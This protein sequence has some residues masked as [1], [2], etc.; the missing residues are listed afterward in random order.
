[1]TRHTDTHYESDLLNLASHVNLMGARAEGM[2]ANAIRAL[3]NRDAALARAVVDQDSDLDQLE[4][5]SDRRCLNILARR[6]PVGED[7]RFVTSVFKVVTDLER[8]G[9]LAVNIA[10]RGLDLAAGTG[11]HAGPEIQELSARVQ[12]QLSESIRAFGDR[13]VA[14]ARGL[15]AMD[16]VVDDMNRLAFTSLLTIARNHPDQIDR[17]L[18]LSSVCKHLERI[19]DHAVNIGEQTVFLVEGHDVRHGG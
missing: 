18:S 19:G 7:L 8:V 6:S 1:M 17:A 15:P 10:E 13:D 16:A 2:V 9:D 5:E 4:K 3:F 12:A 11:I 14:A